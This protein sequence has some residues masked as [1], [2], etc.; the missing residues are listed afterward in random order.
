[1]VA[2]PV[3]VPTKSA[4]GSLFSTSL[5][6]LAISGWFDYSHSVKCEV[7]IHCGL[8]CISLLISDTEHLVMY[9]LAICV[10]SLGKCLVRSS[11]HFKNQ[12]IVF[13]SFFAIELYE[14]FVHFGY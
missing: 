1:M 12:I 9:W 7:I 11:A 6:A 4:Q 8:I 2:V 13:L 3:Y 10:S 14:L 5:A